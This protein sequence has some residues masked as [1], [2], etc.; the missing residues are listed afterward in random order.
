[1]SARAQ[2]TV[3][4]LTLLSVVFISACF[5]PLLEMPQDSGV[6]DA[7]ATRA[8]TRARTE[9]ARERGRARESAW[10]R[11][12]ARA[13][14]SRGRAHRTRPRM[15][16]RESG[17]KHARASARSLALTSA[18]SPGPHIDRPKARAHLGLVSG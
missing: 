15:C 10:V 7:Q 4:G 17:L 3:V 13:R 12:H 9:G 16:A 5:F 11:S 6:A 14:M 18:Q 1:M 8:R 2:A